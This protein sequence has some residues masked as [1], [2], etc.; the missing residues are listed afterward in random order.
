MTPPKRPGR[1]LSGAARLDDGPPLRRALDAPIVAG[2]RPAQTLEPAI[3]VVAKEHRA[4][5]PRPAFASF[6]ELSLYCLDEHRARGVLGGEVGALDLPREPS[7]G[8]ARHRRARARDPSGLARR[9]ARATPAT[10]GRL[11]RASPDGDGT[12]ER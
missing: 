5:A 2:D 12:R 4:L 1:D 11:I 3:G 10:S 7:R 6:S 8:S 9:A